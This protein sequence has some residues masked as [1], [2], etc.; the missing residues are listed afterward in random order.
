MGSEMC[1]RDRGMIEF[2]QGY[3]LSN[4]YEYG[5]DALKWG[6]DYFIK[7]HTEN[8]DFYGQVRDGDEDHAFLGTA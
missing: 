4:Q 1:I 2:T 7:C 5:L 8:L 6:T 3:R